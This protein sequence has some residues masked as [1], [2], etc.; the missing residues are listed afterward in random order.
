MWYEPG[1]D[2]LNRADVRKPVGLVIRRH[3]QSAGNHLAWQAIS[4][5]RLLTQYAVL[6]GQTHP[7]FIDE[8]LAVDMPCRPGASRL[9]LTPNRTTPPFTLGNGRHEG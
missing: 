1:H 8:R 4:F 5:L 6:V 3:G 7:Q 2:W 9:Q